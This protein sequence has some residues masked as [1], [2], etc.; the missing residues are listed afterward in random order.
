[1]AETAKKLSF[2]MKSDLLERMDNYADENG[3]FYALQTIKRLRENVSRLG[4]DERPYVFQLQDWPDLHHRGLMLDIAR[5][6]TS[7]EEIMKLLSAMAAYKMNVFLFYFV[8][9]GYSWVYVS[10]CSCCCYDNFHFITFFGC[11]I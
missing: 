3:R 6:F 11:I 9:N 8:C 1:M 2:S 5:N 10:S 7:K 4:E